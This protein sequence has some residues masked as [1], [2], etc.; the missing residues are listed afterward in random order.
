[1]I[2]LQTFQNKFKLLRA[3]TENRGPGFVCVQ[4]IFILLKL[5]VI[6]RSYPDILISWRNVHSGAAFS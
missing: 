1:M 3:F 4:F 6:Q 2:S 5:K